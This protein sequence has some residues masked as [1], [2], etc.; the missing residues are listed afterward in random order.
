[1]TVEQALVYLLAVVAGIFLF[2]GLA[3]ALEG[4]H[5]VPCRPRSRP[6]EADASIGEIDASAAPGDEAAAWGAVGALSSDSAASSNGRASA[7]TSR[8]PAPQDR[9]PAA[10]EIDRAPAAELPKEA[11]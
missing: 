5:A 9:A 3:Q 4:R 8:R 7:P 10:P 11:P 1:M 6:G 2:L